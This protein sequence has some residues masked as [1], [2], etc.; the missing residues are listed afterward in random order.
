MIVEAVTLWATAFLILFIDENNDW[1]LDSDLDTIDAVSYTHLIANH[2]Q[3]LLRRNTFLFSNTFHT[4]Q[5]S[6]CQQSIRITE[7]THVVA[8]VQGYVARWLVVALSLIHILA[9]RN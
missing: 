1:P 3:A 8:V 6:V 9:G 2:I 5:F 4:N 7:N